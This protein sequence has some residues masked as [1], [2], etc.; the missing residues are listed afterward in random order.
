[1][2]KII[3]LFFLIVIFL[4]FFSIY[5]YYSSNQ[6]IKTIN[7]NR[8]NI[9]DVIR[10]KNLNIP[11][12]ASDTNDVIKFNDSFAEEIRDNKKRSFWNLLKSK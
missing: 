11:I 10:N 7:L 1:M 8:S 6:N 2:Y 9:K 4:F 5:N 12:L 3:N